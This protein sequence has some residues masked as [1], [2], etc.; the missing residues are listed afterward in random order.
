MPGLDMDKAHFKPIS[1]ANAGAQ[2]QAERFGM[3]RLLSPFKQKAAVGSIWAPA[4]AGEVGRRA[5]I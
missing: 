4:F 1:P 5:D 2:M 3:M